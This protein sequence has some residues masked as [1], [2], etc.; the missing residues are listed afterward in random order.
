MQF[1]SSGLTRF[2]L[3]LPLLAAACASPGM[4]AAPDMGAGAKLAKDP[5][6]VV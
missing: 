4:D 2:A 6:E 3:V 5:K 1:V